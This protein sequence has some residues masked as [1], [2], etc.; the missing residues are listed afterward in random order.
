[1]PPAPAQ[2]RINEEVS[3]LRSALKDEPTSIDLCSLTGVRCSIIEHEVKIETV[4]QRVATVTLQLDETGVNGSSFHA[5]LANSGSTSVGR[6]RFK[7]PL[8]HHLTTLPQQARPAR[9]EGTHVY[10]SSRRLA[11]TAIPTDEPRPEP[12][13]G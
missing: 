12:L 2:F 6:A 5:Q 10:V 3:G 8:A 4:P 7:S 9:V 11:L 1:M 13:T